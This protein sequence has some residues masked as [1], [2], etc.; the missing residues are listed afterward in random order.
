M[1]DQ[2]NLFDNLCHEGRTNINAWAQ[3]ST[4]FKMVIGIWCSFISKH[5]P[6]ETFK[7]TKLAYVGHL[8][9]HDHFRD[10]PIQFVNTMCSIGSYVGFKFKVIIPKSCFLPKPFFSS[11]ISLLA[12]FDHGWMAPFVLSDTMPPWVVYWTLKESFHWHHHILWQVA[13][14][15]AEKEGSIPHW[16]HFSASL[17]MSTT[18]QKLVT[19]ICAHLLPLRDTVVA[20]SVS[21]YTLCSNLLYHSWWSFILNCLDKDRCNTIQ[22]PCYVVWCIV[23][24]AFLGDIPYFL[25]RIKWSSLNTRSVLTCATGNDE[26]LTKL[27]NTVA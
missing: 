2:T 15:P 3:V 20:N 23:L 27:S 12:A 16:L 11:F 7:L 14:H 24:S 5:H 13:H 19:K 26:V 6:F 22:T 10:C 9:R 21:L 18:S 17:G 1:K 25:A 4:Q 8:S